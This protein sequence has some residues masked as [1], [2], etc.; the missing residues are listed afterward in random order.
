VLPK[1]EILRAYDYVM[2][3]D[4]NKGHNIFFVDLIP[5]KHHASPYRM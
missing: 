1:E 3:E 5:K 2:N 4:P